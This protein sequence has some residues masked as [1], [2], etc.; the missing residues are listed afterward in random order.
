LAAQG[1]AS[2]ERA[3]QIDPTNARALFY[4]GL[5]L[6]LKDDDDAA[7]DA[8]RRALAADPPPELRQAIEGFLSSTAQGGAQTP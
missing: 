6:R 8:F 3:L 7:G 1:Q 4:R 2:I 5:A